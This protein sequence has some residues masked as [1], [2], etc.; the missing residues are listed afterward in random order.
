MAKTEGRGRRIGR[1]SIGS[2]IMIVTVM[3]GVAVLGPTLEQFVGQRQRI[4]ELQE[5]IETVDAEIAELQAEQARWNDPA[6]IQAQ[7][8]GRLLFVVPGETSYLVTDSGAA[9]APQQPPEAR[10]DMHETET[11]WTQLLGQSF[12]S[13]GLANAPGPDS[14]TGGTGDAPADTQTPGATP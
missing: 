14:T 13:S 3:L 9:V 7:A 5:H 1:P 6:Y 8:R 10:P 12:V 4:A 11:D 2:V